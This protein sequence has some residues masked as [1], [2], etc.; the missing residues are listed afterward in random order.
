M[1]CRN[2]TRS[3]SRS[4]KARQ[5]VPGEVRAWGSAS[6]SAGGSRK[7][8][9]ELSSRRV[10]S[11]KRSHVSRCPS[12]ARQTLPMSRARSTHGDTP[13]ALE[14]A[15]PELAERAGKSQAAPRS[16][17]SRTTRTPYAA[18]D[19]VVVP[20]CSREVRP[21]NSL[22]AA[23][24]AAEDGAF[25]P[26]LDDLE[27]GDGSVWILCVRS[28]RRSVPAIAAAGYGSEEDRKICLQA[29]F[30]THLIKPV[31]TRQLGEAVRISCRNSQS[32]HDPHTPWESCRLHGRVEGKLR[33]TA[34]QPARDS[35]RQ[36]SSHELTTHVLQFVRIPRHIDRNDLVIF[37]L[38][39]SHL[40]NA[41]FVKT[42]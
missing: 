41:V 34:G 42:M 23:L 27:L 37:N 21:A 16:F 12:H 28:G 26:D 17:S 6:R 35:I 38:Q 3:S 19:D 9:A 15:A 13:T 24:A 2:W 33:P 32:I 5:T 39:R 40:Q 10:R 31:E 29:G 14:P 30:Q 18:P 11:R 36:H 4:Y 25:E 22:R 8:T 1:L 20:C 7:P